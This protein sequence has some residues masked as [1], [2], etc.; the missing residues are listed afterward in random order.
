MIKFPHIIS[1]IPILL[2]ACGFHRQKLLKHNYVRPDYDLNTIDTLMLARVYTSF[3][4]KGVFGYYRDSL[5]EK[6]GW[7]QVPVKMKRKLKEYGITLTTLCDA[8]DSVHVCEP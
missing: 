4:D 3:Y 6:K 2:L 8:S 7:R 1:I 5:S